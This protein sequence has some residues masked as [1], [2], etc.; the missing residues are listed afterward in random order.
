MIG[1]AAPNMRMLIRHNITASKISDIEPHFSL[2]EF[3]FT[4]S[5]QFSGSFMSP[6]KVYWISYFLFSTLK[7]WFIIRTVHNSL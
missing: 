4:R 6:M 7:N 1:F 2:R 3:D 5:L